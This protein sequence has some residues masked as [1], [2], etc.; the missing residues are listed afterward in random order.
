M[1]YE[2]NICSDYQDVSLM[3]EEELIEYGLS[4]MK[5][6]LKL[7]QDAIGWLKERNTPFQQMV[8][9]TAQHHVDLC[10]KKYGISRY[11]RRLRPVNIL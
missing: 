8:L 2:L 3:D 7:E 4:R 9:D 11:D 1:D 6:M 10:E 5:V